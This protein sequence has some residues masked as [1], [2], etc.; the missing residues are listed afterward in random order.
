MLLPAALA[1]LR[2]RRHEL[3]CVVDEYGG[4]DG[5]VTIEDLAEEVVGEITDEHDP[6]G[7]SIAGAPPVPTHR[8]WLVAGDAH[9]D[10]IERTL[11]V[12][13]P[14]GE[15]ETVAGLIMAARGT[16][17]ATGDVV[18]VEL[19]V[20]PVDLLLHDDPR[21]RRLRAQVL[22]VTHHVPS[23]V[24]LTLPDRPADEPTDAGEAR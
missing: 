2:A 23:R 8:G 16:L 5:I 6:V 13:L 20:D 21:P 24:R 4:F 22:D 9:L 3:A 10:E 17:P 11:R 7:A 18:D 15:Y 1:D 14:R 19:P 12:E